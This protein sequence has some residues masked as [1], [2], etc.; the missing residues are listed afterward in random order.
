VLFG[1]V[2]RRVILFICRKSMHW[3]LNP[4]VSEVVLHRIFYLSRE[5][6][7]VVIGTRADPTLVEHSV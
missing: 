3:P 6:G 1:D 4:E 5:A 2:K 7:V